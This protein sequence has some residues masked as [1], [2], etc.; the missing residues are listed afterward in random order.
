MSL[1][2]EF[3]QHARK[4][5]RYSLSKISI[6]IWIA[7]LLSE[8]LALLEQNLVQPNR[9]K[10]AFFKL[11]ERTGLEPVTSGLQSQRSPN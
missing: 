9:R 2:I 5:C 11:V 7:V 3:V 1:Q 4:T 6:A 8:W 10:L